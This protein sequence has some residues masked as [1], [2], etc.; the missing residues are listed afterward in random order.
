VIFNGLVKKTRFIAEAQRA[1]RQRRGMRERR[2]ERRRG[3]L[4]SSLR[5]LSALS[6]SAVNELSSSNNQCKLAAPID[7]KAKSCQKPVLPKSRI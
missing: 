3:F 6:T 7:F 1:Q 2:R 5:F 4:S